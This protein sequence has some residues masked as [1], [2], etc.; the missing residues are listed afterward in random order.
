MDTFPS[1]KTPSIHPSNLLPFLHLHTSQSSS[2]LLT[3]S[4]TT[5]ALDF[6]TKFQSPTPLQSNASSTSASTPTPASTLNRQDM[7]TDS[8]VQDVTVAHKGPKEPP[9]PPPSSLTPSTSHNQG[10]DTSR[11][12][13][14][15]PPISLTGI[16]GIKTGKQKPTCLGSLSISLSLS[17]LLFI[18]A[19]LHNQQL[20]GRS[21]GP[22]N[23]L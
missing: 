2:N 12:M 17:L 21:P 4:S 6:S 5:A 8:I 22:P 10:K 3:P 19:H 11:A 7:T 14:S 13:L 16:K 23:V 15:S 1:S 18:H 9:S 20:K